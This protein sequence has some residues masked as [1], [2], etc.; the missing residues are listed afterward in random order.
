[1]YLIT[2]TFHFWSIQSITITIT[3]KSVINCNQLRL[4]ITITPCLLRIRTGFGL[5][6]WKWIAYIFSKSCI[7]LLLW[8]L[9]GLRF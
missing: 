4:T 7:L 3:Q 2:I 9:F 6:W 8:T 1:M 5:S